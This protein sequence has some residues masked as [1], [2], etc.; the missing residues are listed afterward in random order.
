MAKSFCKGCKHWKWT[1]IEWEGVT[2]R[3]RYCYKF[4][5]FVLRKRV[6][7]CNGKYKEQ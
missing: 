2:E 3:F 7:L 5:E 1:Y 6:E 4:G